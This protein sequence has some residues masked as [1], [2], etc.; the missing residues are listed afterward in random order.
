MDFRV[1]IAPQALVETEAIAGYI[2]GRGSFESAERWLRGIRQS[3]SDLRLMPANHPV[4]FETAG[5]EIR[6]LLF[7]SKNRTYK[8]FYSIDITIRIV[9]V[10]HVR[11]WARKMPTLAELRELASPPCK[12]QTSDQT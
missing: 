8:I 10:F 3:L 6:I 2:E 5:R 4:V 11:H 12:S 1:E 7:G 9:S